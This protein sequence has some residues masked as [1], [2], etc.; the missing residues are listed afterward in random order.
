MTNAEMD[1]GLAGWSVFGG[2]V[3]EHR[4]GEDGNGFV[5]ATRRN[6]SYGSASQKFAMRKD[7]LYT[8]SG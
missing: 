2:A 4:V 5:V 6:S 8:L 1:H 3:V 7:L